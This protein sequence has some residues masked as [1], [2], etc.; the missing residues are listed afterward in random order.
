MRNIAHKVETLRVAVAESV[1]RMHADTMTMLKEGRA[2]KGD[3][4]PHARI[5]AIM[6]AKKTSELIPYCHP[7][8]IDCVT[9]EFE[10][11][12]DALRVLVEVTAVAKTGVEMEAMTGASLAALTIYDMLKP[13][14]K[15][16]EI[17]TCRLLSKQG[18]KSSF[19]RRAAE[20]LRAAVL[21]ASDSAAAGTRDDKSGRMLI[22]R[23]S[24]AGF[25][26]GDTIIVRD[27]EDAIAAQLQTLANDGVNLVLT[28][29]G[30]GLGPRDVVVAATRKVVTREAPGI[31]EALRGYGQ[32]RTPFAMM[33][34]GIAGIAGRT[35]IVN[36][37]GSPSSVED[38]MH[39]LFP[40]LFHAFAMMDGGG[41]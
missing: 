39:A 19:P 37:P 27:D 28:T 26:V 4:L 29:G 23:L 3:P 41:H 9:V 22:E 16:M 18:G 2:P 31:A 6:G 36:L 8:L 40:A 32:R 34:Q 13:V 10:F 14:D 25:H 17:L 20:G 35:L 1:I 15:D 5:S 7:L 24:E 12:H 33:S 38:A 30:T 21:V 11:S